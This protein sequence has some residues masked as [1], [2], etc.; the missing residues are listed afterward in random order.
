ML[1]MVLEH[2][3]ADVVALPLL[4]FAG[5]TVYTLMVRL[6]MPTVVAR[7]ASRIPWRA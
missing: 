3:I 2:R 5:A 1:R 7:F 6:T 4:M